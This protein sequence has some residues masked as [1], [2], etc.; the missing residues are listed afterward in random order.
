[1]KPARDV[2]EV[3][4]D[5]R[6][7]HYR[8]AHQ[9][10]VLADR[11]SRGLLRIGGKDA[12]DLLHRLTTNDVKGLRP[13][14]GAA[15]VFATAKGRILD[16]V[17]LARPGG[18]LLCL[19]GEGR[20]K[21]VAT[22]IER[23]TFR[24][25]VEVEDLGPSRAMLGI[26]GP[27]SA[28]AVAAGRPRHHPSTVR[29]KDAEAILLRTEPLAGE[30]FLLVTEKESLPAMRES[31][32]AAAGGA[33]EAEDILEILRIEAGVPK[34]GWELTEEYNP[35]EARLDEAISLN[36]GCYVGQ[37]VIARLN[38]YDKVSKRLVRLRMN[39]LP[40]PPPGTA[41]TFGG[42]EV[43]RLTSV[44]AVPGEAAVAALGYARVENAVPG[45]T[46][47]AGTVT[48]V[49]QGETR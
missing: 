26:Y 27:K 34:H 38:T 7:E 39:G 25:E 48:A 16:L 14:E 32:A 22:W 44:A 9:G 47:R 33:G 46:L 35:W 49:V 19:T 18:S 29:L 30:G 40:A 5:N 45:C 20:A 6:L 24:E 11:S 13:G 37:E 1:M 31:L 43:G 12:L 42:Q 4:V 10:V 8:A 17:I 36:K 23:Y 41:L 2:R 28:E 3:S 15:T 21:G